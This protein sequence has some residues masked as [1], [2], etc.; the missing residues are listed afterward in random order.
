ME[1]SRPNYDALNAGAFLW[2]YRV[3]QAS[4][5]DQTD[6]EQKALIAFEK[7]IF[8]HELT[9]MRIQYALQQWLNSHT[10]EF[11][12]TVNQPHRRSLSESELERFIERSKNEAE[13]VWE[14][15]QVSALVELDIADAGEATQGYYDYLDYGN[16]N[17]VPGVKGLPTRGFWSSPDPC[18]KSLTVESV[19]GSGLEGLQATS[20]SFPFRAI[21]ENGYV[22]IEPI[23][24]E[25]AGASEGLRSDGS[26]TLVAALVGYPRESGPFDVTIKATDAEGATGDLMVQLM[27]DPVSIDAR[28]PTPVLGDP[29]DGGFSLES[30]DGPISLGETWTLGAGKPPWMMLDSATGAVSGTPES[31]GMYSFTV[32]ASIPTD[33]DP[34]VISADV[35]LTVEAVRLLEVLA[36]ASAGV[37][38]T[39]QYCESEWPSGICQVFT[40]EHYIDQGSESFISDEV[41]GTSLLTKVHTTMR[42]LPLPFEIFGGVPVENPGEA[43]GGTADAAASASWVTATSDGSA[44]GTASINVNRVDGSRWQV[45]IVGSGIGDGAITC[46]SGANEPIDPNNPPPIGTVLI[47]CDGSG[48]GSGSGSGSATLLVTQPSTAFIALDCQAA[49]VVISVDGIVYFSHSADPACEEPEP[50]QLPAGEVRIFA[51]GTGGGG[52]A[53]VDGPVANS[54]NAADVTVDILVQ[55]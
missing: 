12:V 53:G 2:G 3:S 25:F 17:V 14:G 51:T 55:E 50:I 36:T 52:Q 23:T 30:P 45:H 5:P 7:L 6:A 48:T 4:W 8:D 21:G 27:V 42:R 34:V 11:T 13:K 18:A 28:L 31:G 54:S 46:P 35:N 19:A 39:S 15:A 37:V 24:W 49:G 9:H 40:E 43:T 47:S 10:Y 33:A 41:N 44:E 16:S 32:E 38:T 29:Y 26:T 20:Q 1:G 22:P